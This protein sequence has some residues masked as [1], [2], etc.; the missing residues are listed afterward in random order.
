MCTQQLCQPDEPEPEPVQCGPNTCSAGEL[1]CN[2]SCGEKIW[3][4]KR[5]YL[6]S[7]GIYNGGRDPK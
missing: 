6:L 5:I 1:C 2:E 3:W 7:R 4:K